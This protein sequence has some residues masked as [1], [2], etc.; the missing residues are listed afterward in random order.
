MLDFG[1]MILGFLCE[2]TLFNPVHTLNPPI[3]VK[4]RLEVSFSDL[5]HDTSIHFQIIVFCLFEHFL[6]LSF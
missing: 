3:L 1:P 6:E 2:I 5:V 4:L